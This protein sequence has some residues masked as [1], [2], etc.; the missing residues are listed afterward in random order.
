M[1]VKEKYRVKVSEI[2]GIREGEPTIF[3]YGDTVTRENIETEYKVRG[4]VQKDKDGKVIK[5]T[6]ENYIASGFLEKVDSKS[7]KTATEKSREI[8]A[9]AEKEKMKKIEAG[10]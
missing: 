5:N 8:I 10:K 2:E 6:L 7:G 3:V 9:E 4:Q 1:A